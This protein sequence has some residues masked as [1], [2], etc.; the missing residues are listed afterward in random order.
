MFKTVNRS[1]KNLSLVG[2]SALD[3]CFKVYTSTKNFGGHHSDSDGDHHHHHTSSSSDL[4][5]SEDHH[6]VKKRSFNKITK[7]VT[8]DEVLNNAKAPIVVQQEKVQPQE[9]FANKEEYIS[10]L[11]TQF[12]KM[13]Q[14][15]YP[16]Y[17]NEIDILKERIYGFDKLNSYQQEVQLLNMY[18]LHKLDKERIELTKLFQDMQEG[19]PLEQA[20]RRL[21]LIQSISEENKANKNR[22]EEGLK[23]KL[24]KVINTEIEFQKFREEYDKEVE[25]RLLEQVQEVKK[26]NIYYN[27]TAN[28]VEL[29]RK[30][31]KLD[32]SLNPVKNSI[33]V[34]PHDHIH[35]QHYLKDPKTVE[36]NKFKYLAFFDI[37]IDQHLRQTRPN[38]PLDD[39]FKFVKD[40]YV[41]RYIS[42]NEQ[43]SN[44]LIEYKNTLDS[45]YFKKL[46]EDIKANIQPTQEEENPHRP[47]GKLWKE[48]HK[49]P[50]VADRLGWAILQES[51]WDK[52]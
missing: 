9:I 30:L 46:L 12:Q 14:L 49:Y 42:E 18:F 43:Y 38:Q 22:I 26:S 21:S 6:A 36:E 29:N 20:R 52:K 27:Y 5:E 45:P 41:P 31:D 19:T 8:I 15:K 34:Y 24:R 13:A 33:S 39:P 51:P 50:H 25:S 28:K 10:F 1:W 44:Y 47:E 7:K 37:I 17:K 40:E 35:P 32:S 2:R 16:D 48:K 11:T 3:H 4:S 23:K